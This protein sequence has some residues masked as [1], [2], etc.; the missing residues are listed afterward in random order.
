MAVAHLA[1]MPAAVRTVRFMVEQPASARRGD[2]A[3]QVTASREAMAAAW[4]A[5]NRNPLNPDHSQCTREIANARA[6]VEELHP[7]LDLPHAD[8]QVRQDVVYLLDNLAIRLL[9]HGDE[10]SGYV[11]EALEAA[12]EAMDRQSAIC[13]R[14]VGAPHDARELVEAASTLAAIRE[15]HECARAFAGLAR[16]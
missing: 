4:A 8:P 11:A 9:A 3:S 13:A 7:V 1:P 14:A 15:T 10:D 16:R 5:S 2:A 6:A 12:E